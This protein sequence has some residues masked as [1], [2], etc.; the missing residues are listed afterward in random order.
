V[1]GVTLRN[2]ARDW[3]D[4][5]MSLCLADLEMW[6]ARW[7]CL[8]TA[9]R[10]NADCAMANPTIWRRHFHWRKH[11]ICF[12]VLHRDVDQVLVGSTGE[13]V[14]VTYSLERSQ[15]TILAM[16]A[17]MTPQQSWSFVLR[18]HWRYRVILLKICALSSFRVTGVRYPGSHCYNART[19]DL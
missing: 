3:A 18:G 6:E 7:Q 11:K 19:I 1:F 4:Q 12:G 13:T 10:Q 16:L 2:A 8:S 17:G 9:N 14:V 5:W 15:Q